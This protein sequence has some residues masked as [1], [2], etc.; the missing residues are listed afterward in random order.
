MDAPPPGFRPK[1]I[2]GDHEPVTFE[3]PINRLATLVERALRKIRDGKPIEK[4][5]FATISRVHAETRDAAQ[6]A[7]FALEDLHTE[8][9][10]PA[11]DDG[12]FANARALAKKYEDARS[13]NVP[14]DELDALA[15]ELAQIAKDPRMARLQ[16]R[17]S[18]PKALKT[19]VEE[20][21]ARMSAMRRAAEAAHRE[22]RCLSNDARPACQD[23]AALYSAV[24]G[25]FLVQDDSDKKP[26]S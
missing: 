24:G 25:A 21:Q 15:H 6:A 3:P 18:D 19:H 2:T 10:R 16:A 17:F 26:G 12:F 4:E 22:L 8:V 1:V 14:Q 13:A 9:F 11:A 20:V 23:L 7:Q 5:T